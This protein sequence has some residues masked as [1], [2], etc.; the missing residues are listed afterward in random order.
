MARFS[1]TRLLPDT[2][3]LQIVHVGASSLEG[4]IEA[5]EAL[6][7][8][9]YGLVTGFEPQPAALAKLKAEAKPGR[10]FLPYVVGNGTPA[11]F[12]QTRHPSMTSVLEPNL[13][14]MERFHQLAELSQVVATHSV[15][16][17]RLDDID[18]LAGVDFLKID[19]QGGEL[20]VLRGAERLLRSC[21]VIQTEVEFLP[22]YKNQPLF[23]DIDQ[24]L[25]ACGFLLHT[26]RDV[27]G[28]CFKPFIARSDPLATINQVLW[29]DAIY[30]AD[31]RGI[32]AMPTERL[33][34][35]AVLMHDIYGS[36]DLCL[37]ILT[38]LD[39]RNGGTRDLEGRYLEQLPPDLG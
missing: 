17:R 15:K 29:A 28:R 2:P 3:A 13:P 25:R 11:M 4:H 38:E 16:T 6:V 26:F 5:Y 12:H 39:R 23:G 36:S 22:L 9:G 32:E 34:K 30:V 1:L 8:R 37:L 7:D 21:L 33:Q 31:F 18:E 24:H 14:L 27:Q 35:L 19:V 20:E 10:R